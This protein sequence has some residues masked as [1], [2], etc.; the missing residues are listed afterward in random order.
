MMHGDE[1]LYA[2]SR[3]I[4]WQAPGALTCSL[5]GGRERCPQAVGGV[6]LSS[7]SRYLRCRFLPSAGLFVLSAVPC[8]APP[9]RDASEEAEVRVEFKM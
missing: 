9:S 4:E 1:N 2:M 6:S 5:V 7:V 3:L 8:I